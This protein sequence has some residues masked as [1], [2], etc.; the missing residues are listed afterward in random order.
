MDN[1]TRILN[2]EE[3]E[4][5]KTYEILEEVYT[6]LEEKGYNATNQIVGYLVSGD[7]GYISS[8][9]DARGKILKLDR[10]EIIKILFDNFR[11]KR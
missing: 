10:I 5:S 2:I 7:P 6:S 11:K 4:T 3:V 9:Q 8:Y 1:K